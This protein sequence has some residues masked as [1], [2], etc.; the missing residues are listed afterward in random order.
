MQREYLLVFLLISSHICHMQLYRKNWK[1]H[2]NLVFHSF[3]I[4]LKR[5]G[6]T[7][8]IGQ[9]L[10]WRCNDTFKVAWTFSHLVYQKMLCHVSGHILVLEEIGE[11]IEPIFTEP[12]SLQEI[13]VCPAMVKDHTQKS[14]LRATKILHKNIQNSID[15]PLSIAQNST[16][17]VPLSKRTSVFLYCWPKILL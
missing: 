4:V 8:P 15:N 9:T 6:W 3:Q 2:S 16:W 13:V 7:L 5:D 17:H 11:D 1:F 14:M 10:L 12:Q